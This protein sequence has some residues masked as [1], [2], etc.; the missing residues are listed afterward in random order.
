LSIL[1]FYADSSTS[2]ATDVATIEVVVTTLLCVINLIVVLTFLFMIVVE[3]LGLRAVW[4]LRGKLR[5][6]IVDMSN[7]EGRKRYVQEFTTTRSHDPKSGRTG[8]LSGRFDRWEDKSVAD[9]IPAVMWRHPDDVAV[10]R[11]PTKTHDHAGKTVW[12]FT[13]PTVAASRAAPELLVLCRKGAEDGAIK[14]GDRYCLMNPT[15]GQLSAPLVELKDVGGLDVST[16]SRCGGS[17][18]KER[19]LNKR[20]DGIDNDD[21]V[22]YDETGI[23]MGVDLSLCDNNG[24]NPSSIRALERDIDLAATSSRGDLG[25]QSLRVDQIQMTTMTNPLPSPHRLVRLQEKQRRLH[26]MQQRVEVNM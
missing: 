8:S 22:L 20:D 1:Y 12:L 2:P 21:G 14:A 16:S 9:D 13:E 26:E 19:N 6:K 11:P 23:E 17:N 18:H 25:I 3:L 7:T 5:L 10:A 4:E 15:T 24:P